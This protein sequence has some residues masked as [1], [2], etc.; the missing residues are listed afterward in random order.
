MAINRNFTIGVLKRSLITVILAPDEKRA[1]LIEEMI[2]QIKRNVLPVRPDRSYARTKGTLA[3]K[4][5][6]SHKRP[7]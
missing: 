7:Y 1:A 5:S 3:G 2:S 6:N 4:Y